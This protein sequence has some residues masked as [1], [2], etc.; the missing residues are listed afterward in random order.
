M[1]PEHAQ[2]LL[3]ALADN[4]NKFESQF[5]KIGAGKEPKGTFNLADFANLNGGNK[6]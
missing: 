6:S 1:T 3:N 5:G 4:I 2:R